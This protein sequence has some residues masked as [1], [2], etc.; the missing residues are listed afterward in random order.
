MLHIDY[1]YDFVRE[2]WY[3]EIWCEW[4]GHTVHRTATFSSRVACVQAA[5]GWCHRHTVPGRN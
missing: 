1:H 3:A 2:E 5:Q 4:T